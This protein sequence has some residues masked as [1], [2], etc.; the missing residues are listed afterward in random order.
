M[1]ID[2]ALRAVL[3]SF[4]L[5]GE[6]KQIDRI[7][8]KFSQSY[9]MQNPDYFEKSNEEFVLAYSLVFLNTLMHNARVNPKLKQTRDEFIKQSKQAA[10][11]YPIE[12]FGE[13]YDR[14]C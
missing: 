13:M 11:C 12:Q 9:K 5:P 14:I 4:R 8:E 6:A 1:P 7:I 3:S 10:P 2:I